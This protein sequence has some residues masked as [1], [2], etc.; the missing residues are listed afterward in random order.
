VKRKKLVDGIVGRDAE[1]ADHGNDNDDDQDDENGDAETNPVSFEEILKMALQYM[2]RYPPSSLIGLSRS[3]YKDRWAE[4]LFLLDLKTSSPSS[5][6]DDRLPSIVQREIGLLGPC[7]EFSIVP[8]CESDWVVKQRL[9]QTLGRKGSSR[10]HRRRKPKAANLPPSSTDEGPNHAMPVLV[11]PMSYIRSH[12]DKLAVIAVGYGRG[13]DKVAATRRQ[14]RRL[15]AGAV[16][17]VG[18]IAMGGSLYYQHGMTMGGPSSRNRLLGGLV[19]PR[20]ISS[21]F[22]GMTEDNVCSVSTMATPSTDSTARRNAAMNKAASVILPRINVLQDGIS[23][24][25]DQKRLPPSP[26][27]TLNPPKARAALPVGKDGTSTPT[28]GE[29]ARDVNAQSATVVAGAGRSHDMVSYHHR[30]R[31]ALLAQ[32]AKRLISRLLIKM[33]VQPFRRLRDYFRRK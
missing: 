1:G 19:P 22:Y 18:I 5:N 8:F 12:P 28:R 31:M 6:D 32:R 7:P 11:D 27:A 17:V 4:Q 20:D 30:R 25:S 14:R 13:V 23:L 15:L 26:K 21:V 33:F 16:V 24:P 9:R 10:K 3:Y 29:T 2:K